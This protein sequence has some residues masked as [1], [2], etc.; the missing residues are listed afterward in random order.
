[1]TKNTSQNTTQQPSQS[2]LSG[3]FSL[4]DI[5]QVVYL[6]QCL[7]VFFGITPIIGLI[8][9]LLK[10][11]EASGDTFLNAHFNWQIKTFVTWGILMLVGMLLSVVVIGIFIILGAIIWM[12]YR[13]IK[14]WL[15]FREGKV[16]QPYT[17]K[18]HEKRD[19]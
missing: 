16:P 1:M 15:A 18:K 6:L 14:G 13:A 5:T 3:G 11:K 12:L 2:N 10:R 9:N 19:R 7:G 4:R 17:S 8:L